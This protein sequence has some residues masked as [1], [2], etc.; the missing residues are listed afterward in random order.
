MLENDYPIIK[1]FISDGEFFVYDMYKNQI[2]SLPT[3]FIPE[4]NSIMQLGIKKYIQQNKSTYEYNNILHLLDRGYFQ[5]SH[6]DNVEFPYKNKATSIAN[7]CLRH[8]VLQVTK[9]CNFKC[10]YCSYAVSE[11]SRNHELVD[12]NW[13]CAKKS[14]DF[15]LNHSMDAKVVMLSFYGGEP[16]LNFDLIKKSIEYAEQIFK[17]KKILYSMT[18]NG[19][20]LTEEY[21]SFLKKYNVGLT[22]SLDGPEFIQNRNRKFYLSGTGTYD[23]VIK[24]V[25]NIK[26]RH[27]EYFEKYVT[28]NPVLINGGDLSQVNNY[29]KNVLHIS[30]EKVSPK[31]A[32]LSGIDYIHPVSF[33]QDINEDDISISFEKTK[34]RISMHDNISSTYCHGGPCI[35]GF[36]KLFVNTEGH[37]YLCEK[38]NELNNIY[39]LGNIDEGYNQAAINR[40]Y[41]IVKLTEERCK[42]CWQMRLCNV[43]AAD[44]GASNSD[45]FSYEQKMIKCNNQGNML[46]SHFKKIVKME[47]KKCKDS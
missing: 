47:A 46:I 42:T 19:S 45:G 9:R 30:K 38:V 23:V 36:T 39:E 4:V 1:P 8:M 29:F 2:V 22:I 10:R 41:D 40:L 35:P 33:S 32:N 43:C 31:Y 11:F 16:L 6:I 21:I 3:R 7:R 5:S 25:L 28:F 13:D 44:C 15:L 24:N 18:C 26:K 17:H 37:F 34:N 20:L 27:S 14:I 12:M